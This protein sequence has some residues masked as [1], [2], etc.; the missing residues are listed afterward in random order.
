MPTDDDLL[1]D[2]QPAENLMPEEPQAAARA[3]QAEAVPADVEPPSPIA[4]EL[5]AKPKSNVW[6]LLMVITFVAMLTGIY[7][8]LRELNDIYK[9]NVVP[10]G[11]EKEGA[12]QP[13][14]ETMSTDGMTDTGDVAP[15]KPEAPIAAPE[16]PAAEPAPAPEK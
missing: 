10:I 2:E 6:T 9:I 14:P 8:Q 1:P 3:P 11:G 4:A 12:D 15:A 5:S 7:V 16:T 13:A